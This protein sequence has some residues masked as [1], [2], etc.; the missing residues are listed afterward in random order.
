MNKLQ[1]IFLGIGIAL[2]ILIP[3]WR[4]L[5]V[6]E[7]E[8]MPV[9]YSFHAD[10]VTTVNLRTEIDGNW[11]GKEIQNTFV[12]LS[13]AGSDEKIIIKEHF[14]AESLEGEV[15]YEVKLDF[16]IDPKTREN[17]DKDGF[18]IF[19]LHVEKKDYTIWPFGYY[20]SSPFKFKS[21]ETIK[22]LDVYH[23]VAENQISDDSDGFTWLELVPDTYGAYSEFTS[24]IWIEPVSGIIVKYED[25][26]V[27]YYADQDTR[28]RIWDFDD[29]D[30][31][32]KDDTI[33]NQ[34]RIA[35]NKKQQ[36]ILFEIIIPIFLAL[37]AIA[38]LLALYIG[39]SKKI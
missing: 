25:D 35:Q 10:L 5:I 22:G 28:E 27:S 37:I 3:V 31:K 15:S 14:R 13:V 20:H 29:W 26:G 17:I 34:V 16:N 24:K 19:P 1:K 38:L 12:D 36:I 4:L 23:F 8:K 18:F 33:A 30:N 9:D 32:F 11:T 21:E 7:L 2:F 6:P 39:G